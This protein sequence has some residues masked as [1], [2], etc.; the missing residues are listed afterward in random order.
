MLKL[1]V[2]EM[3]I[4]YNM[5][6]NATLTGKDAVMFSKLLVKLEKEIEKLQPGTIA[7]INANVNNG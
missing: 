6:I 4:L 1:E 5:L 3:A 2:Q 7:N